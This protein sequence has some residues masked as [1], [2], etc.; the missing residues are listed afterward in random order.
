MAVESDGAFVR[1]VPAPGRPPW[2]RSSA[3]RVCPAVLVLWALLR[4]GGSPLTHRGGSSKFHN[5]ELEFHI[6]NPGGPVNHTTPSTAPA[7]FVDY[8]AIDCDPDLRRPL[9]RD[10][11]TVPLWVLAVSSAC[12]GAV[13]GRVAARRHP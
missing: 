10:R 7:F 5:V 13:V 11:S 6:T 9:D 1:V 3:D 2:R 8:T 4:I 12:V